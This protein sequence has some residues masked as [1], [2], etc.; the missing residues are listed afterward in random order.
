MR[1]GIC[2]EFRASLDGDQANV[3]STKHSP[4][5]KFHGCQNLDPE[6]TVWTKSQL[7]EPII[8][9][10]IDKNRVWMAANLR[11]KDLLVV[12]FWTDWAYLNE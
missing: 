8:A 5:L 3:Q 7:I 11:E 1:L 2:A 10:R 9:G 4:L 12:G 6:E